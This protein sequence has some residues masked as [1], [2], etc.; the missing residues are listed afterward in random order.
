MNDKK[1]CFSKPKEDERFI[2][3]KNVTALTGLSKSYLYALT[4]EG[5]FPQSIPLVQGGVAKAWLKSE[6]HAWMAE[7]IAE[8]NMG[9]DL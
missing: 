2:R 9:G 5:K 7:R 1:A 3:M 4:A 8:R 6:V